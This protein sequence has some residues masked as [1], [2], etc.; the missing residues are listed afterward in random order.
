MFLSNRLHQLFKLN[1]D[2]AKRPKRVT[3]LA[4][5]TNCMIFLL[6]KKATFYPIEFIQILTDILSK[7]EFLFIDWLIKPAPPSWKVIAILRNWT[8]A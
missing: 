3:V 7:S 1:H 6:Y 2:R 5:G 4:K 8:E